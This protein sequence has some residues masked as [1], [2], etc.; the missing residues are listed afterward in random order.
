MSRFPRHGPTEPREFAD[1]QAVAALEDAPSAR[2]ADGAF[3]GACPEAVAS[4]KVVDAEVVLSRV[5]ERQ[6]TRWPS[7]GRGEAEFA[8]PRRIVE[9]QEGP[10]HV[11]GPRACRGHHRSVSRR[12]LNLARPLESDNPRSVN[13]ASSVFTGICAGKT[14]AAASLRL[15]VA[16]NRPGG[17]V[18]FARSGRA[19]DCPQCSTCSPS[20]SSSPPAAWPATRPR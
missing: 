15:E 16:P 3:S 17:G 11:E 4:M 14:V 13:F 1:D 5:L 18:G 8:A 20:R 2:R 6:R 7:N 19:V 9:G 10:G 12:G